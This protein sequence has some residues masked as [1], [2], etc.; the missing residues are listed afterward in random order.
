MSSFAEMYYPI[1]PNKNKKDTGKVELSYSSLS[2]DITKKLDKKTKSKGGIFFTP[3]STV[4]HAIQILKPYIDKYERSIDVLEPSC[5][6]G[7]WIKQMLSVSNNAH[8]DAVEF[9]KTIYDA[10]VPHFNS[11]LVSIFNADFLSFNNDN[12]KKYDFII[13]NPPYFKMLKKNVNSSL[14]KYFT[15]T[16][17][18]YILFIIRGLQMLKEGGILTYVVPYAFLSNLSY[19]NTR[20]WIYENFN[21]LHI[22]FMKDKYLE[23]KIKTVLIV[24]QKPC[25]NSRP[26]LVE[27][28]SFVYHSKISIMFSSADE[29]EEMKSLAEGCV[30]IT[31]FNVSKVSAFTTGEMIIGVS[32]G[33]H[34]RPYYTFE[35]S[36]ITIDDNFVKTDR[37]IYITGE[38]LEY[39]FDCLQNEKTK[40]FMQL[41]SK[42]SHLNAQELM[43]VLPVFHC[44][45]NSVI[46]DMEK[47]IIGIRTIKMPSSSNV[48]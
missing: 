32:H 37:T 6:S 33:F 12:V 21:I 38:N 39:L 16:P 20:Q 7:E 44:T 36:L 29:I 41:Y 43:H 42:N 48:M 14:Y 18:I 15:G 17:N 22:E 47:L 24:F 35:S 9:D 31:D 23:T 8:V 28:D 27:N 19:D 11:N 10:I 45:F 40:R 26:N 4:H 3:P 25:A 46:N 2:I 1:I 5:G 30:S 34:L 13:G